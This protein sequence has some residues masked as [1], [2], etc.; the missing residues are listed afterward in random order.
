MEGILYYECYDG[1]QVVLN[2]LSTKD[3][4]K[5]RDFD[6]YVCHTG[7]SFFKALLMLDGVAGAFGS[8]ITAEIRATACYQV[9]E[10]LVTRLG[11]KQ[12]KLRDRK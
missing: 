8:P 7:A 5:I 6:A 3:W 12:G 4:C 11:I 2:G 1:R 10:D 9:A